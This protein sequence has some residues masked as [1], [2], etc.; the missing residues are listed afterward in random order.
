M[1]DTDVEDHDD[2]GDEYNNEMFDVDDDDFHENRVIEVRWREALDGL[3]HLQMQILGQPG[4]AGGL[5]DVAAEPF[6][7]VNVDDLFR[8]QSFERRRQT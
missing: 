7:G 6:E 1:A 3:D 8:L 5:I 2:S 4:A